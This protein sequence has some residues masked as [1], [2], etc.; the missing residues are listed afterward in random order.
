MNRSKKQ[1][2]SK[3]LVSFIIVNYNNASKTKAML[4]S[5]L[6]LRHSECINQIIVV[7][8]S[9]SLKEVSRLREICSKLSSV[10]PICLIESEKN[11]GYS[12]GLNLGMSS[13]DIRLNEFVILCNNDLIFDEHFISA[14]FDFTVPP[15]CHVIF[16]NVVSDQGVKENPRFIQRVP[17]RRIFAYDMYY[18]HYI[19]AFL[20]DAFL[21]VVRKA[22]MPKER[23]SSDCATQ[24]ALGVGACI[25]LTENFFDHHT[26]LDD[27]VFLWGEEVLLASMVRKAG[28]TQYYEPTLKVV[29]NAHSSVSQIKRLEKYKM[30]Q[31]SYR[32]FRQHL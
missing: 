19:N 29:H 23:T 28:G 13:I 16:P 12:G 22:R 26:K 20:I 17:K 18:L 21:M 15:G 9:S 32:I 24:C 27:R 7:D 11:L 6:G 1:S 8:N 3:N 14:L 30:M 4:Y 5:M 25:I 31:A 10:V 2:M